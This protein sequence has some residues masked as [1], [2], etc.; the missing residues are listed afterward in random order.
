MP[1]RLRPAAASRTPELFQTPLHPEEIVMKKFLLATVFV[2]TAYPVLAQSAGEKTGVNSALGIAPKTQDFVTQA[3]QSDML[4]IEA[5]KLA[6][7]NGNASIK[8]F[9][10]Q[11]VKDHTKTSS[12]LKALVG[13]NKISVTLP[14][15]LDKAHQD[16]LDKLKKLQGADFVKEYKSMQVSAHKDAVSLFERYGQG[17]DNTPLKAWAAKTLPALQHH[18]QM[19]QDME[20]KS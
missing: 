15:A 3:A 18:L 6:Q 14:T 11:M 2:L 17:G 10:D 7:A 8:G 20:K 4:E 19:A 12:E 16:K 13:D 5:G 9:A 1:S